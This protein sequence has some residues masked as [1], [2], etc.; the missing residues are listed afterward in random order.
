MWIYCTAFLE[1]LFLCLAGVPDGGILSGQSAVMWPYSL[2]SK[3]IARAMV[4][5]VSQF[6]TISTS[7][8]ASA[9]FCGP[10]S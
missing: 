5:H 3:H 6:L 1:L 10:F 7:L 4:C 9:K 8:M 2:Q